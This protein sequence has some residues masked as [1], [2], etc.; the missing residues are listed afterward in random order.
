MNI[1]GIIIGMLPTLLLLTT[2]AWAVPDTTGARVT[3]VT[4]SAFALVWLTDVQATPDVEVYSDSAMSTRLTDGLTVTPY[5][6]APMDVQ[7]AAKANGIMKARV[8]GLTPNSACYVRAVT[9]DPANP[10]SVGYSS[11]LPVTTATAVIPY[12]SAD[13]GTFPGFANDLLSLKVYIR[14]DYTGSLAGLGDLLLLEIPGAQYPVSSFA[15][16]GQVAPYGVIDLNNLFGPDQTSLAVAG[17]E[18]TVIAVYRGG[19]LATLVHYRRLPVPT[20][21]I[22]AAEPVTGFFADLN[23]DGKVDETDLALFKAQFRTAPNDTNYNPDFKFVPSP[24]GA[25]D[26]QDFTRFSREYGRAGVQ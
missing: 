4:T 26:A 12:R 19:P 1:I 25:I 21:G 11:L 10:A 9:R 18:K 6:D 22:A 3:D 15:G 20:N 5:P 14:P 2:S 7:A 17:G 23:L 24:S 13:D 8:S 16:V